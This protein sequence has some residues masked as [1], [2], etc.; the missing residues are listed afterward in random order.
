MK[1]FILVFLIIFSFISNSTAQPLSLPEITETVLE[2]ST[3]TEGDNFVTQHEDITLKLGTLE[4]PS[5]FLYKE[6]LAPHQGYL[7]KF[8]DFIRIETLFN[9]INKGCDI[10]YDELLKECKSDLQKCQKDCDER[11]ASLLKDK[12]T[13]ELNL[14]LQIEKTDS[15]VTKKYLWASASVF[16]GAGIVILVNKLSN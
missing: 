13:L 15:E 1:N 12:D 11:V 16:A 3:P 2:T 9:N 10:L 6:E 4:F 7:I 8:G 5:I 14:K